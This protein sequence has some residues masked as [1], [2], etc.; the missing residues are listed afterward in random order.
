MVN[1]GSFGWIWALGALAV[2]IAIHLLSRGNAAS[3]SL[4]TLR[5]V[6]PAAT[7]R[8]RR[9]RL[10]EVSLLALRC[11]ALSLLALALTE[12]FAWREMDS[13]DGP[14]G[15]VLIDP[16]LA[17]EVPADGPLAALLAD[18][19]QAGWQVS[20][21]SPGLPAGLSAGLS[22]YSEES[23][24][25]TSGDTWS[26]LREA[27]WR[28]P[29]GTSFE[30]VSA[31]RVGSFRGLRP[32]FADRVTW[33][34]D[35]VPT[36]AESNTWI[37]SAGVAEDA[38]AALAV[39]GHSR[40]EGTTFS[41]ES[42]ALVRTGDEPTISLELDVPA[43][44]LVSADDRVVLPV[45][46]SRLSV[47]LFASD[48][49]RSDRRYLR[50]AFETLAEQLPF[51]ISV[52]E[53]AV[54]TAVDD[55]FDLVFWLDEKGLPLA[56][57]LGRLPN[58][59]GVTEHG[60]VVFDSGDRWERCSTTVLARTGTF[61]S[62]RC[63]GVKS[64][65]GSSEVVWQQND[66]R[67]LLSVRRV[68]SRRLYSFASRF[69]PDWNSLVHSPVF[70][71]WLTELARESVPETMVVSA[72]T[73]RSDRSRLPAELAASARA[74]RP[75]PRRRLADQRVEKGLWIALILVL[76]AERWLAAGRIREEPR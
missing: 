48:D 20:V 26:L 62:A 60:T 64:P 34:G 1:F 45:E 57:E 29:P 68:G 65:A 11:L 53:S 16:E 69:R 22:G 54:E 2:P 50:V 67:P 18:R 39:V 25:V 24:A 5:F 71:D 19:S 52:V 30:V 58:G 41:R 47:A 51:A 13:D 43:A 3:L 35:L 15:V 14:P 28:H 33:R 76:M 23:D 17:S 75:M 21:L 27:V 44:D 72:T 37:H 66:G 61:E 32:R 8:I 49:R 63:E 56:A 73:D 7:R 10:T 59:A 40:S 74:D 12:P 9:L 46:A 70:L 36:R 42:L 4:G 38:S 55:R 31:D 6:V